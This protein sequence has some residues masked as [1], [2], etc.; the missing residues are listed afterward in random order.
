MVV[1]FSNT[2]VCF[3]RDGAFSAKLNTPSQAGVF[4]KAKENERKMFR[5][6]RDLQSIF[7]NQFYRLHSRNL[8]DQPG[9]G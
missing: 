2:V 9:S 8:C 3:L 1:L 5:V 7:T 6:L 4:L